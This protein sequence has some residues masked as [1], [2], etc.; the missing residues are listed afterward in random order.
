MNSLCCHCHYKQREEREKVRGRGQGIRPR[1][2]DSQLLYERALVPPPRFLMCVQGHGTVGVGV[3][4]AH[5][6]RVSLCSTTSNGCLYRL[7]LFPFLRLSMKALLLR[8]TICLQ[9]SPATDKRT[10]GPVGF[11]LPTAPV[12][13]TTP[14]PEHLEPCQL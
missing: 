2:T 9:G 12:Y 4:A 13:N 5:H 11:R 8:L 3:D 1:G 6:T 14:K 7:H 10:R